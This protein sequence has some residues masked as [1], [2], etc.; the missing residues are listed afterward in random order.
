MLLM[1]FETAE[2][3]SMFQ[4]AYEKYNKVCY[5]AALKILQD[6]HSAEDA[7]HDA[8]IRLSDNMNK[9]TLGT[10]RAT[11]NYLI[12]IVK[13]ICYTLCNRKPDAAELKEFDAPIESTEDIVISSMDADLLYKSISELS[14][15]F[16]EVIRLKYFNGLS[17]QE[18]ADTLSISYGLVGMRL[19]RA[20]QKLHKIFVVEG[21]DSDEQIQKAK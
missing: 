8:F 10:S 5:Y 13:N 15:P 1:T 9:I 7:V 20:K 17:N 12:T 11:G 18:I 19:L 21:E 6:P 16:K 14:E 3:R 2:E 4:E